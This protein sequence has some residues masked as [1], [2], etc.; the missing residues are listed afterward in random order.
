MLVHL[1][2]SELLEKY[3]LIE[4]AIEE[5]L[6]VNVEQGKLPRNWKKNPAPP[7][8]QAIGDSWVRGE[9]SAVLRVPSALVPGED[10][11]ILNP[12]QP[13]FRKLRIGKPVTL[14]FDPRLTARS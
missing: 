13:D 11:F 4:V 7:S 12:A 6:I 3:V 5:A 9:S 10:N 2:S 1:D 8:L 14:R